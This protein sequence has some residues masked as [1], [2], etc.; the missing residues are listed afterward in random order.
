V[1]TPLAVDERDEWEQ[2]G[3]TLDWVAA[4]LAVGLR[5]DPARLVWPAVAV[6]LATGLGAEAVAASAGA[7]A[8]ATLTGVALTVCGFGM[9]ALLAVRFRRRGPGGGTRSAEAD[10][11]A[12]WLR[13]LQVLLAAVLVAVVGLVLLGAVIGS[14]LLVARNTLEV[15][16]VGAVVLAV[17]WL[18]MDDEVG[19]PAWVARR[20]PAVAQA[21]SGRR[22]R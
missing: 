13:R 5:R 8:A 15:G 20:R 9:L 16:R 2:V 21:P 6:G 7:P 10:V 12:P 18:L 1:P 17:S 19:M 3:Q 4:L 22:G 11:L 14:A